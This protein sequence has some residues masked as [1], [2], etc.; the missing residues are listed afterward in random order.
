MRCKALFNVRF[1]SLGVNIQKT[2]ILV[3]KVQT[4]FVYTGLHASNE[5][6][7]ETSHTEGTPSDL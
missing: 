5:D 6:L 1:Y 2:S 4:L 3:E 7:D